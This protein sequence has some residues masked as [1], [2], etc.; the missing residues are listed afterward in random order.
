MANGDIN[1]YS[2]NNVVPKGPV[3]GGFIGAYSR[4]VGLEGFYSNFNLKAD[5]K[6]DGEEYVL[7]DKVSSLG[8]ALRFSFDLIYI[9]GGLA[10]FSIQESTNATGQEAEEI[11]EIYGLF[12]DNRKSGVM[13]GG[14]LHWRMTKHSRVFIDYSRYQVSGY[15]NFNA[16]SVG[17]AFLIPSEMLSLPDKEF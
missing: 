15:G 11:K 16:V 17:L 13:F 12:E 6:H 9:R 8:L 5:I 7:K 2:N 14:G 10:S 3:L 1:N 4:F